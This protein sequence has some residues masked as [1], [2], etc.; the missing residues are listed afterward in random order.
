MFD[1]LIQDSNIPNEEETRTCLSDAD[2]KEPTNY[3]DP[4]A[5]RLGWRFLG[6]G[7]EPSLEVV[8]PK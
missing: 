1:G 7:L 3:C 4:Y 2:E 5:K 8:S 6:T